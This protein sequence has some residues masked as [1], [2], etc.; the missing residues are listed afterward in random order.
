M[1]RIFKVHSLEFSVCSAATC[2]VHARKRTDFWAL[3]MKEV[4]VGVPPATRS[5]CHQQG[6]VNFPATKMD[7]IYSAPLCLY[8]IVHLCQSAI[9]GL[10]SYLASSSP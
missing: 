7:C 2:V 5:Y 3:G 9:N 6:I 8:S 4:G 1:D 10:D